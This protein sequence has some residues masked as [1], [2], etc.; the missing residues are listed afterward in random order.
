MIEGNGTPYI[1][2]TRIDRR[3]FFGL[4][5]AALATPLAGAT[6]LQKQPLRA[7][8]VQD[9][10][11]SLAT[12]VDFKKTADTFKAGD[13]QTPV[14]GI[15]VAWMS[16]TW[17][18]KRAVEL[19]CNLFI[20]HEP[21]FYDHLDNPRPEVF[22]YAGPKAKR[23]F[24][25]DSKLVILR[26]HDVW[27][28]YPKLGVADAWADTLGFSNPVAGSG[29]LRAFD[30]SGRT[31]I[32]VARQVAAK[33]KPFGQEGVK[34]LGVPETPVHRVALGCGAITPFMR[35][36]S[37]LKADLCICSDDGFSYWR[38]GELA[39]DGG[40]PVIVVNHCVAEERSLRL[41]AEHLKQHYPGVPV[42]SIPEQCMY[43]Q[44]TA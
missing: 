37:D 10:L 22:L 8:D 13:P 42:H 36:L 33:T 15:A 9:Y 3:H 1:S 7:K 44:V 34:L 35:F 2:M 27:D 30:V 17:A 6:A 25:E 40:F 24:I 31:A 32:D 43:R 4:P 16:Y 28:Q 23:K 5:A 19:G 20:T 29:Y 26:C 12:W 21:T 38:D 39:I 11:W 14:K 41:L 18:L